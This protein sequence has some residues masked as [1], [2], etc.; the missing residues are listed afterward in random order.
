MLKAILFDFDGTLVD[1]ER[2]YIHNFDILIKDHNI[3][4]KEEDIPYLLGK[5]ALQKAEYMNEKY[6]AQI[7]GMMYLEEFRKMNRDTIYTKVHKLAYSDA[8]GALRLAK[9]RGLELFICSNTPSD[10]IRYALRLFHW[11]DLFTDILSGSDLDMRKPSPKIYD[12]FLKRYGYEK[13]EVLV[14]EDSPNGIVSSKNAGIQTAGLCR[15]CPK[16]M[17]DADYFLDT[18]DDL[19][20][21]LDRLSA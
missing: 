7:D 3:S 6:G 9:K 13:E 10:R 20:P 17:M 2:E 12:Y 1:T 4:S 18:L 19:E 5:S 11:E 21:L 8:E 14:V 15:L 16:E